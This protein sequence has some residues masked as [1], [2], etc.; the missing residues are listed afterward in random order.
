MLRMWPSTQNS[1]SCVVATWDRRSRMCATCSAGGVVPWK[2]QTTMGVSQIS[3]SAIQQISSSKN[4]G[5]SFRARQRSQSF[6][7][8]NSGPAAGGVP[9]LPPYLN[10]YDQRS[11][12]ANPRGRREQAEARHHERAGQKPEHGL[13]AAERHL[14]QRGAERRDGARAIRPERDRAA[15]RPVVARSEDLGDRRR[16]RQRGHAIGRPEHDHHRRQRSQ[17]PHQRSEEHTS[18]LQSPCNLVCRLLL[19]KKKKLNKKKT[20]EPLIRYHVQFT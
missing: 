18:E 1:P 3:H 11:S 9:T 6:T 14:Q 7:R 12:L 2:R 19:E 20:R 13:V 5:V 4:Q 15:D 16:P 8:V 10:L 17:T